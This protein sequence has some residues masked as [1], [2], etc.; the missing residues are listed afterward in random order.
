[1]EQSTICI[2]GACKNSEPF[3]PDVL[4]NIKVIS[5]WFKE[6]RVVIYEND[7][8]DRTHEMLM[9]W[10][11]LREHNVHRQVISESNL[12]A[13][14]PGRTVRL[15]HI[16]NTLLHHIPPGF[17]YF[18]M[19][20]LDDV[21][22]HPVRKESFDSCFEMKDKWDVVTANGYGGYYD[23]WALRVPGVIEFDCWQRYYELIR[24]GKY[25][26]KQATYEAIEKFKDYMHGVKEPMYVDG[27]F[28]VAMISKV[29][30]LR[31]CCRYSGVAD[32]ISCC[33]HY[34]FQKCLRSHGA[35]I[36]FN[37]NFRL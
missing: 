11:S 28:N 8:T 1:M 36:L 29:S 14:F 13:R 24:S 26:Q 20:D 30:I 4:D 23:I 33:E 32:N 3:L 19:V 5:S 7:S 15:A 37:P 31:P 10:V 18:M 22:T 27:A 17:D 12:N 34:P 6:C 2:L 25:T 9:E 21:F 35:R 16:R